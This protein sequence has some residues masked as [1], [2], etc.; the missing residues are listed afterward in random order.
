MD[1]P[2][3]RHLHRYEYVLMT[4]A[5][6][7]RVVADI[8]GDVGLGSLILATRAKTV[9]CIDPRVAIL[10][11]HKLLLYLMGVG[12][13]AIQRVYG[14]PLK[15]EESGDYKYDVG[16]CV[17]VFE[18]VPD[19]SAFCKLVAQRCEMAFWTT[20]LVAETGKTINDTHVAEYSKKDFTRILSESFDVLDYRIQL[21]DMQVV[22]DAEPIGFSC[23]PEHRVQ[24]AWCRSKLF[25]SQHPT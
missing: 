14:I 23:V 3:V 25:S 17:E 6:T 8:G 21:S 22:K 2:I 18:H 7:D 9:F 5:V 16:V 20:P 15:F 12:P 19:P 10:K 11:E 4:D 13:E 1:Y 24:M